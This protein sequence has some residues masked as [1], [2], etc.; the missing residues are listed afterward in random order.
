[1]RKTTIICETAGIL[2]VFL[3]VFFTCI[4]CTR[5]R[6]TTPAPAS[7]SIQ[8]QTKL[9]IENELDRIYY[10]DPDYY[11]DVLSGTDELLNYIEVSENR[12]ATQ[13]EIWAARRELY[14]RI[15]SDRNGGG[16]Q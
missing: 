16:H 13:E 4:S 12:N 5:N 11:L 2:Y 8:Q 7:V 10:A 9:S 6:N 15:N 1:M 3:F 14:D